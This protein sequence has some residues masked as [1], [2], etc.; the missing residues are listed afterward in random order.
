METIPCPV[1]RPDLS[2]RA[3]SGDETDFPDSDDSQSFPEDLSLKKRER[4]F[5]SR[6]QQRCPCPAAALAQPLLSSTPPCTPPPASPD[7]VLTGIPVSVIVKAPQKRSCPVGR[8]DCPVEQ[9]LCLKPQPALTASPEFWSSSRP[10]PAPDHRAALFFQCQ[11]GRIAPPAV[12]QPGPVREDAVSGKSEERRT[13]SSRSDGIGSRDTSDGITSTTATLIHHSAQSF[14]LTA[15]TSS[16][17]RLQSA[18]CTA[19]DKTLQQTVQRC[20][21]SQ[22]C[23]LP[24]STVTRVR[25]TTPAAVLVER[26]RTYRCDFT[27]CSKTYYKSSHLK[28]HIR[29][30]TGKHAMHSHLSAAAATNTTLRLDLSSDIIPSDSP[31]P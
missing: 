24:G 1:L 22:S 18:D 11:S 4:A 12:C 19:S 13:S 14:L 29:S 26:K 17:R 31:D 8:D 5:P 15:A 2:P 28:A 27:G 21:I 7:P 16:N 6:D 30:H 25:R 3:E 10:L 9:P 20:L 23:S